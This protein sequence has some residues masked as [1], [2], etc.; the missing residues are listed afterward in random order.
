[1]ASE[2]EESFFGPI[3]RGA[4]PVGAE[5]DPRQKSYQREAME[6]SWLADTHAA[7]R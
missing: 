6:D 7:D 2:R 3:A 4:E 1:M 5:A